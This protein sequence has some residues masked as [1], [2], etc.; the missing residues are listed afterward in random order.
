MTINR[1]TFSALLASAVAAPRVSFAQAKVN[2]AFY[3]GVGGQLT[4][5]EVDFGAATLAKL[6]SVTL[7]GGLQYAWPHPSRRY[8]YVATSSGGVGIA[9]VPGYPPDQHYLLAFH[10]APD[11]G[12]SGHGAPIRL[13]QRPIH[14][15][16]DNAGEHVLVAYNFPSN[17]SVYKIKGDGGIGDEVKQPDNLEKGIYFHQIRA[18]PGDKSILIVARGNNPE[19]IQAGRPGL[20]A[21]LR[22]QGRR[23]HEPA[24]DRAEW[25]LR[26]RSAP[27][28]HPPVAAVGIR[29]DRAAEPVDRLQVDAGRRSRS[30]AAVHHDHARR[31]RPQVFDPE[32]PAQFMFIPMAGSSISA[33]ARAS[34][35]RWCPASR[36]SAARRCS[37]AAKADI[38]VFAINQQTGEPTAIQHADIRAAHPR[39]FGIDPGGR[40]LVAGS[41]AATAK[42]EGG[43]V[44]DIPA[45]LSCSAWAPTASSTSRANTTSMS[46]ELPN[47]GPA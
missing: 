6:A 30:G 4:H 42:R 19:A 25:R 21:R 11:G 38:A 32:P 16:V 29:V 5:Y 28:R 23:A 36:M 44:V 27:P 1:R 45:G 40:L 7:P 3:S 15:S 18:T 26:L 2:S 33:T 46:G 22:L 10:V 37:A 47:G 24:Q 20:A 39:T 35:A 12:L 17:V 34:R 43:K 13:R 9:P 41:L 14:L 8:L 31:P